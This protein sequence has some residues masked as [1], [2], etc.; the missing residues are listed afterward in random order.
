MFF[1]NEDILVVHTVSRA[2]FR[3]LFDITKEGETKE[4]LD[5]HIKKVGTEQ[6]NKETNFLKHADKDAEAEI[7][8][9]FYVF[10]E[11]GIGMAIS[12][13]YHHTKSM[14]PEMKG[15]SIWAR[16]MRPKYFDLPEHLNKE[17]ADWKAAS[18]TD[19]DKITEQAAS[20]DFGKALVTALNYVRPAKAR[21]GGPPKECCL[22]CSRQFHRACSENNPGCPERFPRTGRS[23]R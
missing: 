22:F 16:M 20:R 23:R 1:N 9:D 12:L 14:S 19:P 2:A 11:A 21:S 17:I 6:F 4:A 18:A 13:H 8:E 10:T 5:A 7:N 15:F 3:V